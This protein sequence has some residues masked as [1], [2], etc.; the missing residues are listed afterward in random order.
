M[1]ETY[2]TRHG[3][4]RYCK[5]SRSATVEMMIVYSTRITNKHFTHAK[6]D[7]QYTLNV[8]APLDEKYIHV[9]TYRHVYSSPPTKMVSVV[10]NPVAV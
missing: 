10:L 5:L 7:L 4:Y 1:V 8:N 3:V 2:Q 6:T 9:I